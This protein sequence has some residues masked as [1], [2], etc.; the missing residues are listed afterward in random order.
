MDA[1]TGKIGGSL[2]EADGGYRLILP[3][4]E[5]VLLRF[6]AR[7]DPRATGESIAPSG[8]RPLRVVGQVG[9]ASDWSLTFHPANDG[10]VFSRRH[11]RLGNLSQSDDAAVADF[12][13]TVVYENEV[14]LE[15][16]PSRAVLNLGRPNGT[17]RVLVNDRDLGV[18]WYGDHTYALDGRLMPG[19]NRVRI[20]VTTTIANHLRSLKDNATAQRLAGWSPKIPMGLEQDPVIEIER[21]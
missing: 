18:K 20:E 2:A 6:G 4:L 3:T 15:Q 16:V 9:F 7:P 5:S 8:I 10:P 13:G 21:R 19:R 17:S 14:D 1:H 12:G 11:G